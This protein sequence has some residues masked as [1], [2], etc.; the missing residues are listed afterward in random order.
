MNVDCTEYLVS[1]DYD[2]GDE[3]RSRPTLGFATLDLVRNYSGADTTAGNEVV[4]ASH[5]GGRVCVWHFKN[6]E[7]VRVHH[8]PRCELFTPLRVS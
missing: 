8:K 6:E 5:L 1:K 3:G 7:A 2:G 4:V